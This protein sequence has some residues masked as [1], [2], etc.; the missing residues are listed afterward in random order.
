[1]LINELGLELIYI[2]D[3]HV[4]ADHVTG[5]GELRR[6]T[7]ALS[8]VSEAADVSCVDRSLKTETVLNLGRVSLRLDLHPGTPKVASHMC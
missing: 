5:A 3:T 7:G 1:M 8:A 6:R 2:L 4:H